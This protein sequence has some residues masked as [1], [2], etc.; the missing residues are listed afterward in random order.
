MYIFLKRVIDIFLG[1]FLL[2][3][4]FVPM[5]VISFLVKFSSPKDPFIYKGVRA[6][7]KKKNSFSINSGQ[8]W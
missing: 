6:A 3:L 1:L 4:L 8:W 2:V 5:L 7:E